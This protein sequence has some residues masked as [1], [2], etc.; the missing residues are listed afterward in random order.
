MKRRYK[1]RNDMANPERK[2]R[3]FK[4]LFYDRK[5]IFD[6]KQYL[7]LKTVLS[8]KYDNSCDEKIEI[9]KKIAK[10]GLKNETL[11]SVI[12][13]ILNYLLPISYIAYQGLLKLIS[14]GDVSAL[15]NSFNLFNNSVSEISRNITHLKESSLF[16][17]NFKEVLN[18][19]PKI[20]VNA[21]GINVANNNIESIEFKNVTFIYP[22]SDKI[23]L[24]NINFKIKSGEKL[25]IV[26]INGTGKTTIVKLLMRFY[27]TIS[28]IILINNIDIKEYNIKSIRA[29]MTSIFQDFQLYSI[30]LSEQIACEE[31]NYIDQLK[32]IKALES[33]DMYNKIMESDKGINVEYSKQFD[34]NGLI[35]SGGELQKIAISRMIYKNGSVFIMD[36]PSSSLDPISEYNINQIVSEISNKKIL[37]L[38]SHRLSTTKNADKIIFLENGKISECGTHYELMELNGKY[39]FLF[40]TQAKEYIS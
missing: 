20:E 34:K 8:S 9:S 2:M 28:G 17:N 6:I 27:D 14:L 12:V 35:L 30:P 21:E 15:W 7:N 4:S 3:Y 31:D 10:D 23:I 13:V 18:Y 37:F 40:N 5:T 32:V 39:A 24:E 38:I 11:T 36:E 19:Q 33:T 22:N 26:G 29:N 1:N 16:V 25:A